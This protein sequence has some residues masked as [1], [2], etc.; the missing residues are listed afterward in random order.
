MGNPGLCGEPLPKICPGD[1]AFNESHGE[2]IELTQQ[3]KDDGEA[4]LSHATQYNIKCIR[5]E[6]E[7]LLQFKRGI[8]EDHCGILSSW[9]GH[10]DDVGCCQWRG[11]LCNNLTGHVMAINLGGVE[12]GNDHHC[13]EGRVTTFLPRLKHLKY[14]DLSFNNFLGQ[15]IPK[16]ISSLANLEHLNLSNSGFTG[17]IPHEFGNLSHLTSLD[18]SD[19]TVVVKSLGWLSRLTSLSVVNLSDIDLSE[20]QDWLQIITNLPFLK[21]LKMDSCYLPSTIPS[22]LTF[23]NSSSTLRFLSLAHNSFGDPSIF[24]WLFNLSGVSTHLVHLDLCD[25]SLPGSIPN[26][27]QKLHSLSYIDLSSNAFESHIPNYFGNMHS[28]SHLDLSANNLSGSI[29]SCFKNM[30]SLSYLDVSGNSLGGQIPE[31][32]SSLKY[33]IHLDLSWNNFHGRVPKTIGKLCSLQFLELSYNNLTG[34]LTDVIQILSVCSYK[35]LRFF[36]LENN[37]FGGSIPNNIE[38]FSLSRQLYLD[39]NQLNGTISQG[40]AKLSMLE[41]LRLSTNSL[42]GT[43]FDSHFANLSSLRNLYLSENPRL[44]VNISVDW[45][46]PFQLDTIYL[47]SCKVGPHFPKWLQTQ[48][49]ISWID[50][51]IAEIS[52]IVPASFWSSLSSKLEYLNMSHNNIHGILPNNLSITLSEL[53]QIDL[54]SNSLEGAIPSFLGNISSLSLNDNK[55]SDASSFLC[56]KNKMV[57]SNLDLSNNLLSGE[58]PDCWMYFDKLSILS[59]ENNNLTGKLSA[60]IGALK[61]LQA[62]HLRHNNFSGEL[63]ISLHNC[64]SLVLLDVAYNAFTGY[65]PQRIGN[66]LKNLGILSLRSNSF[67][68]VLPSSLC[69]LSHLQI[70]DLS[71]NNFSGKIPRCIYNLTAMTST[72]DLLP[73]ILYQYDFSVLVT[74][75]DS[76]FVMWKGKDQIFRNSLGQVKFIHMSNNVLEGDIPEGISS[77]IGLISLDLSGNK[78]NGSITPKI[79]LLTALELLD[80]SSNNLSGAIPATFT[81][82]NFLG[83]L[84]LSYNH[85]SGRVP[86]GTLLQGF[87]ASAYM[88]NPELCGAPLAICPG[89]EPPNNNTWNGNDDV[90]Q[91]D[92]NDDLFPGLYIS[93]EFAEVYCSRVKEKLIQIVPL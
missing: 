60:S 69:Q 82:L 25:N 28:L 40:I 19:N 86:T 32:I 29:S 81:N 91:Q 61:K 55:F 64:T 93:V 62:L 6:R 26:G 24:Q 46:P 4:I 80:L 30:H 36:S 84:N 90:A 14:L 8:Q 58:L 45:L 21:V 35:S 17:K 11:I 65:L 3:D 23:K 13:L 87:D 92:V 71:H 57:L 2:D 9:E 20:V 85:L 76:A 33:L 39:G 41:T 59:L 83:M 78:L 12:A 42:I 43:I 22:S 72:A 37:H 7:A 75:F 49:Q 68:G 70:L 50:I 18:L 38:T 77:L 44:L 88:G 34:D 16:F 79:G 52:D 63:P 31:M 66:N 74:Y 89:D 51:S 1:E 27:F 73:D 5:E 53:P 47:S 54:S 67:S 10:E 56:P 15:P 48:T